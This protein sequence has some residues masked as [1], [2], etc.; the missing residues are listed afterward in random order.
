MDRSH[1]NPSFTRR[2]VVFKSF[3]KHTLN[4][5]YTHLINGSILSNKLFWLPIEVASFM[6]QMSSSKFARQLKTPD[7]RPICGMVRSDS[8]AGPDVS[9]FCYLEKGYFCCVITRQKY[10]H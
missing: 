5:F 2:L 9:A 8:R 7:R 4:I 1:L 10:M 3:I 6:Y